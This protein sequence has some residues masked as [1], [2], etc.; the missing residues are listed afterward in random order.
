LQRGEKADDVQEDA[1]EKL[2][3]AQ[4]ELEKAREQVEEEL[5]RERM[6]K[7]AD[8]VK[9]VRDRQEAAVK[10]TKRIHDAARRAKDWPRELQASIAGLR[11]SE[12]GLAKELDS[13]NEKHFRSMKIMA[14][15]MEQASEAMRQAAG[16]L[17][18]QLDDLRDRGEF[19][20]ANDDKF[21][22]EVLKWQE[23]ALRRL[24]Q[25]LD[26]IKQDK[27][28]ATQDGSGGGSGSQPKAGRRTDGDDI[29]PLAQLK[30]LRALQAEI[31]Q[32]TERFAQDHADPAKLTEADKT[33]LD[34][35]RKMQR[36]IADLIQEFSPADAGKEEK[37]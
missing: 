9:G 2:D 25:F 31:N 33:E 27:G 10:E 21:K 14:K 36:D 19:D 28:D 34:L 20:A 17:E 24:D 5:M 13:L 30:A 7:I 37:P 22:A 16:R 26:A 4:D 12:E 6:A 15:M 18:I 29:P 11:D 3:R 1:L 35:L 8:L 23:M 32:Q